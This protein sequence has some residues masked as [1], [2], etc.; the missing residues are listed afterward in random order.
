MAYPQEE[1]VSTADPLIRLFTGVCRTLNPP[2]N[3]CFTPAGKRAVL[4]SN[5]AEIADILWAELAELAELQT[6]T[7]TSTT[8]ITVCLPLSHR[9]HTTCTQ[10]GPQELEPA[11]ACDT[12][13]A[14]S[15][16]KNILQPGP[17]LTHPASFTNPPPLSPWRT[18]KKTPCPPASPPALSTWS[19]NSLPSLNS[20]QLNS[21][22]CAG[23]KWVGARKGWSARK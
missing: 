3:R 2:F 19:S 12:L 6:L 21:I 8:T 14:Q 5:K 10:S 4:L 7:L 1:V 20:Q 16:A 18:R 17:T 9:L 23:R 11:G 15:R 13:T 22:R